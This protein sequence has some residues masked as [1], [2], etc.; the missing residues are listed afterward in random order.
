MS[1]KMISQSY[2]F[3]FYSI[4]PAPI[5]KVDSKEIVPPIINFSEDEIPG[6]F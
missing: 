2:I 6:S 1:V 4:D 3:K 5:N